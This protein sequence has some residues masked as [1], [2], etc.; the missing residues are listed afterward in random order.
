MLKLR[1]LTALV[2]APLSL[3][4]IWLLPS[5]GVAVLFGFA[6]LI[7]AREWARLIG[8]G[9]SG[10]LV[11]VAGM[12]ALMLAGWLAGE[13]LPRAR[14]LLGVTLLWVGIVIWLIR[15]NHRPEQARPPQWL[16]VVIGFAVLWPAWY[17][18]VLIHELGPYFIT[19]LLFAVWGADIGAYFAGRAFGR[20]KL[21]LHIS[22]NKTWEG[23]FGGLALAVAASLAVHAVLGPGWPPMHVLLPLIVITVLISVAGDL[24]ESMV[25][26]Q[27]GAKDSGSL[28][29]GHGGMLDR[30]DS[31]TAAG[32]IFAMGLLW[33]LMT[34]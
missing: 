18:F 11:F 17:A 28:L 4:A 1:I 13:G 8:Y 3:A 29:P 20:R 31:L 7:G 10:Q 27:H 5:G 33:W 30:I 12:A 19:L 25:K 32:P 24:F 15:F 14:L 9:R 26:R 6:I 16:G 2:L 21:A 22:P 34:P 23:L